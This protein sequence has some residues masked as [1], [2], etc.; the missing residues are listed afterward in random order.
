MNE[1]EIKKSAE[2]FVAKKELSEKL[3]EQAQSALE[4]FMNA[5]DDAKL[6]LAKIVKAHGNF[7]PLIPFND[8]PNVVIF[9]EREGYDC[10][11]TE[12]KS[13][14]I[15]GIR[16]VEGEGLFLCTETCLENYE[17]DE[18]YEFLS[19]DAPCETDRDEIAKALEEL[20]YYVSFEEDNI[21]KSTSLIS[22]LSMIQ[23]Y[24]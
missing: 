17:W 21:V 4:T 22:I 14:N 2:E 6:A 12:L 20:A 23:Y 5:R 15:Y 7:I 19:F 24:L 8:K 1:K 11:T 10:A 18:G 9:I 13:E 16:Y 3:K